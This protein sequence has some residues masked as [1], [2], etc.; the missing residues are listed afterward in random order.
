[1]SAY[2]DDTEDED[3]NA[4]QPERRSVAEDFRRCSDSKMWKLMMDFYDSKGI[5]SWSKGIVPS[6]VTSN[7]YIGRSYANIIAGF[8]S[9]VCPNCN[10]KFYIIE[11]GGGSGKLAFYILKALDGIRDRLDFPINNIVYVITDF[12]KSNVS[13]WEDHAR[14]KPYIESGRLDFAQFEAVHDQTLKLRVCDKVLEKNTVHN[15]ICI[16]ANYLID[17]LPHDIFQIDN[18]VLK[19]GL[20]SVGTN[21]AETLSDVST[22]SSDVSGDTMI[23]NLQNE[24]KYKPIENTQDYYSNL[25]DSNHF[26]KILEWY[27]DYFS[28]KEDVEETIDSSGASFLLPI[29][30]L[31]AF[32]NVSDFSMSKRAIVISGDKGASNPDRFRGLSSPHIA[33]HGSFSV[34]VNFHAIHLYCLSKGGFALLDNQEEASLVVNAFILTGEDDI[35]SN[36]K[37]DTSRAWPINHEIRSLY[38]RLYNSF[39]DNV[40][41]FSPNDFYLIQRAL[42]DETSKPSL[43]SMVS[44]LKLSNWDSEVFFKFR[45]SILAEIPRATHG[46]R[47]E[48]QRG[49]KLIWDN[50]YHLD[51]EKDVAFELGR[52][53]FGLHYFELSLEFYQLSLDLFGSHHVTHH[54]Q[55]LC[56]SSLNKYDA[57]AICF[58]KSL[59]LKPD[60]EKAAIWLE[61]V[62]ESQI[63]PLD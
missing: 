48:L 43:A 30:F 45:D 62:K 23:G 22:A 52:L 40:H 51:N 6:F 36:K 29:G 2:I 3:E 46:L 28:G 12:T 19:E 17:T 14:F 26:A 44:L 16:V 9:D 10:E 38:K 42:K 49:A 47:N 15:P 25:Q 8:I 61:K 1:M 56:N 58:Q 34:M 54:N 18:G 32:R 57:A 4:T 37:I 59:E 60:Y 35:S 21:Y 50:Y 7:A 27:R 5:H 31:R 39:E 13:F 55:G 53:L 24:Y 33:Y 11:L 41:A 63:S 20:V